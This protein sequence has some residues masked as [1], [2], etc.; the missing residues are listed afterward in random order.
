MSSRPPHRGAIDN[1]PAFA[2]RFVLGRLSG[3]EKDISI[4]LTPTTLKD[5]K[6]V[7]HA[8][9]PALGACCGTIEYLTALYHGN[10]NNIGWQQVVSWAEVYLPQADY[11]E[12]V[13]RVLF[14]V[15]RHPVAHRGISSGIW[16]DRNQG[17]GLGRRM[18]WKVLANSKRPPIRI[19]P[20]NK[21]LVSDPPWPCQ[22]SHRVHIHLKTLKADI[23]DSANRY[24]EDL[25]DSPVLQNSFLSCMRQLY[26]EQ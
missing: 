4:C 20:E 25:G 22:Y 5:T 10:M 23:I 26:P 19:V 9:F 15:F 21:K 12:D 8:Y 16:V 7:T 13:I 2:K 11:N 17:Q 1:L 18:T 3:F 24:I 14:G 6:T